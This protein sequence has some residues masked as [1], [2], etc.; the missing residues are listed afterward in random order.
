MNDYSPTAA[1]PVARARDVGPSITT[2][3]DEIERTQR[4][5]EPLLSQIHAN[6]LCRMLLPRS[7]DGDEVEPWIYLRAIEEISRHDGSVGW[8]IFVANSSALIAPFLPP[9]AMR[10]IFTDPRAVVAWGPPNETKAK[11]APGGYRISGTWN[12]ASGC[13]QATWMGAHAPVV[14]PDGSLRL[15][16]SGKPTIRTLLV[17]AAQATLIDGSW[18][19]IG[20]RGTMSGAYRL[21]DVFVSELFSATREDPSLRREPGRLYAYPMQGIYAVGVAGVGMGIARGMLDAFKDL[22]T[23]KTPRNLGRLA[24]NAVVQSNVAQMEARLG[25][26]RAYLVETLTDIWSADQSWVI[27][28]PARARVRLA[29]AFAIQAAETVADFTY[30]SA[31]VDAI[32]PGTAFERRFRDIHTLSQ[33]IQSRSAHFE[34][35]GQI[36]LGIEPPGTFL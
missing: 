10:A 4:I 30:K 32:F 8:N 20:M 2:A 26:A 25:A 13:R 18:N 16:A 35:V 12:F 3:A 34:S 23:R 22:A 1:D 21:D 24:D 27:D 9:D 17:P 36:L 6:R 29:C 5:P 31:G 28:V 19:V 14:E 7:V 11:A 15:N 33:Q